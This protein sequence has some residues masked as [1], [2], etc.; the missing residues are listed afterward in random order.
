MAS[1]GL[2][3]QWQAQGITAK[4]Q[5]KASPSSSLLPSSSPEDNSDVACFFLLSHFFFFFFAFAD[6]QSVRYVQL[7]QPDLK[8]AQILV[9]FDSLQQF[10]IT[11]AKV[12]KLIKILFFLTFDHI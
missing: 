7:Q 2:Q 6:S 1:P 9:R 11:D 4:V 12:K 10:K 5:V 8:F 3:R